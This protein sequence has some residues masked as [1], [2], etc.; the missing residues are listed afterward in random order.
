MFSLA[1]AA[2]ADWSES[3][4]KGERFNKPMVEARAELNDAKRA[5]LYAEMQMIMRDDGGTIVPFFRNYVYA[6]RSN[7]MHGDKLTANSQLDSRRL[8]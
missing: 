2:D 7:V 3:H 4:Y 8:F 1:Y 6:R 5:E